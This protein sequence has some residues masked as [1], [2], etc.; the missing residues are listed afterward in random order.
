MDGL[1]L[2]GI[3]MGAFMVCLMIA[4]AVCAIC[5]GRPRRPKQPAVFLDDDRVDVP[6]GGVTIRRANT[7]L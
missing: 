5:F 3:T 1:T 6:F 4:S 7:D 2:F